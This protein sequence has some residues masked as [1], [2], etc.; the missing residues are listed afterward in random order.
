VT[1]QVIGSIDLLSWT[2][3]GA[4]I[5]ATGGLTTDT[6]PIN[7]LNQASFYQVGVATAHPTVVKSH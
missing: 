3:V 5:T 1:Y 6:V 4:P 2:N 7:A